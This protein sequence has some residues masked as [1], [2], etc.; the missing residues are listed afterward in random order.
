MYG[1]VLTKQA[2]KDYAYWTSIGNAVVLK[3]IEE[4]LADIVAHPYSGIGKPER[5]KYELSGKILKSSEFYFCFKNSKN[6][7]TQVGLF[8]NLSKDGC[9]QI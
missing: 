9:L 1:I 5:L 4:L 7:P 2:Q 8:W 6:I 3:K